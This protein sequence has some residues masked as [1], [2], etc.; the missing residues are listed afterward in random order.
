[1]KKSGFTLV[2]LLGVIVLIAIISGLAVISVNSVV[3]SGKIGLYKNYET[4]ME[5]AAR[6]YFIENISSLPAVGGSKNISYEELVNTKFLDPFDDPNGG[7]CSSSY[8]VVSRT[9]NKGNNFSLSYKACVI[10]TE[11]K[12]EYKSDGC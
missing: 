7:D 8:V 11:G 6:N 5:G 4:T 9:A 2:E 1:M 3:N 10:C 12:L